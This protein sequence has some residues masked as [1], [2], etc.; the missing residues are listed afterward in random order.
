M[1]VLEPDVCDMRAPW[2]LQ[3]PPSGG[4]GGTGTDEGG[5]AG[6]SARALWRARARPPLRA[7]AFRNRVPKSPAS[8]IPRNARRAPRARRN[9]TAFFHA[10]GGGGAERRRALEPQMESNDPPPRVEPTAHAFTY[11]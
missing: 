9:R 4:L 7:R 1:P 10:R 3:H 6:A 5:R 2:R 11:F 8:A